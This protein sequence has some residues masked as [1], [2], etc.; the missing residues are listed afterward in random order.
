M[1]GK[2]ALVVGAGVGYLFGTRSG[3]ERL[4]KLKGWA[5]DTWNDP[6]VQGKLGDL[7]G[8]SGAVDRSSD[9]GAGS[10]ATGHGPTT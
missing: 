1:K 3:R 2:A 7:R 5:N 6:R 9:E 8:G 4:E 10:T